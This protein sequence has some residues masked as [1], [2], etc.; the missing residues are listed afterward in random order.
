M[1][2][3]W[4]KFRIFDESYRYKNKYKVGW[5]IVMKARIG[6]KVQVSALKS[7][8]SLHTWSYQW[9]RQFS[10][11]PDDSENEFVMVKDTCRDTVFRC[12]VFDASI[13][14][15]RW[16]STTGYSTLY[17][18]ECQWLNDMGVVRIENSQSKTTC[19]DSK[20]ECTL[21][22]VPVNW[23]RASNAEDPS[24]ER[25]FTGSFS[26]MEVPGWH[27]L[28]L[29]IVLPDSK[30]SN[31]IFDNSCYELPLNPGIDCLIPLTGTVISGNGC[32]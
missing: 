15:W 11:A 4:W 20:E 5:Q 10:V 6:F 18:M 3:C 16:R 1:L 27:L 13:L 12:E 19:L 30:D 23:G 28:W 32:Q 7:I 26:S 21:C 25:H 17:N 29:L 8:H 22:W 24:G 2:H 14:D 9:M 31:D